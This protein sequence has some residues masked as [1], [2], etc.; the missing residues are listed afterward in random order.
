MLGLAIASILVGVHALRDRHTCT[1]AITDAVT[2]G[3]DDR[4]A[5]RRLRGE[6]A[7]N[8]SDPAQRIRG[9]FALGSRG[10][11]DQAA[12]LAREM[13]RNAPD[14]YQGWAILARILQGRDAAGSRAA[15]S[16]AHALNPRGSPAPSRAPAR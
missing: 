13:T 1:S 14:D 10:H 3:R 12:G 4:T 7:R 16:R 11:V 6:L 9:V 2:V 15:F 8:C 5:A